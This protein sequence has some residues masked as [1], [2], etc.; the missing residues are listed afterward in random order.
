MVSISDG[1]SALKMASSRGESLFYL[2]QECSPSS[3][4][5]PTQENPMSLLTRY[6]CSKFYTAWQSFSCIL[7]VLI[8]PSIWHSSAFI[9]YF[10]VFSLLLDVREENSTTKVKQNLVE[11]KECELGDR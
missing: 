3:L 11:A 6:L 4:L 10:W 7:A 8:K 2:A 5:I 9:R 1:L